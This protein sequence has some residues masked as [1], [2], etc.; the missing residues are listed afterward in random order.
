VCLAAHAN[1]D[2]WCWHSRF[3]HQSFDSLP[4]MSKK[5]MVRGLPVISHV[6]QLC[7]AC[8]AGKHRRAPFRATT[9]YRATAPL[10]LVHGDLC[11]PIT[12]PTPGGICF[13]LLLVDDHTRFMWI[14]LLR[15]K[16]EASTAL[17]RFQA[18][19]EK[20]SG[21]LL[22]VLCTDRGGEFTATDFAE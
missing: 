20:E 10:E 22:R 11:G 2:A 14:V 21:R 8:I 3:V 15:T 19:A 9:K 17:R 4:K 12:P 6:E 7:E 13:F 16:D 18:E 1:D 5:G